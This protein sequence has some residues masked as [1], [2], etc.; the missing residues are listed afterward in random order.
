MLI[1]NN[2]SDNLIRRCKVVL[3]Q[4]SDLAVSSDPEVEILREHPLRQK[5]VCIYC[6][7]LY[8]DN[9]SLRQHVMFKHSR[10][11]IKCSIHGCSEYFLSRADL[12]EHFRLQH[13]AQ[14]ELKIYKCC[15]CSYKASH[16]FM[17]NHHVAVRH[18]RRRLQCPKC[19]KVF[20]SAAV[21]LVHLKQT[22]LQQKFCEHCC[23]QIVH[24]KR[25]LRQQ[26]CLKCGYVAPCLAHY[27]FHIRDCK[28]TASQNSNSEN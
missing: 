17:L 5:V 26:Q 10:V 13:Q 1:L 21:L 25:H 11:K 20:K 8:A 19:T 9:D 18:G 2:F 3:T 22:H 16:K 27:A 14:E 28:K 23:A 15:E 24:L 6:K 7:N 12:D 4:L